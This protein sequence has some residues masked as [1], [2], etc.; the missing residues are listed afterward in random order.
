MK[1]SYS[2]TIDDEGLNEAYD[3]HRAAYIRIFERLGLDVVAVQAMAGAMGG[4][5]SE[6]FL[7]PSAAGQDT[8]V[9]SPGG[10]RANVEAV[11]TVAPDSIDYTD[12][13]AAE[14]KDTPVSTT[15]AALVEVANELAPKPQASWQAAET[16]TGVALTAIL[17]GEERKLA[18]GCDQRRVGKENRC[19]G[20]A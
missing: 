14:V 1:D 4:S 9:E 6:E 11:A 3:K 8:F 19:R 10:Y 13:P 20:Y 16:L 7:H 2:F 18:V 17:D 5:R 15:I 12:A